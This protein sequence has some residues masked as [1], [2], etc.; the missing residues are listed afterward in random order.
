MAF[1]K[2]TRNRLANFVGKARDL[3]ADEF[4]QQFQSLYGISDNGKV[5][6]LDQLKHLDDVGQAA[7]AL[8]RERIDYFIKTHPEE[9]DGE[10]AAVT[11]LAREQAFT[12]LNRLAAI[13]MAEKRDL[14]V[15][16]VGKGYQSKGF[17][18]FEQV[19]GAGL[20]DTY[21]RYRRYIFCLFD[22]LAVDL[23]IL[24]DRRSPQG[25]LFPRET[26]LQ[27]L[28]TLLNAPDIEPLWGEDETIGWIYQYYNDPAERKKMRDESAAPR[29]SRELAVRNQ[30]FTPR[31]VVE[32][33]TDNT[34][35]RIWYEMTQ[36]GTSL[37]ESCRYLVRRPDEVFF[38]DKLSP[39]DARGERWLNGDDV[40]IQDAYDLASTVNAYNRYHPVELASEWYRKSIE[41]V[42]A[43]EVEKFKTQELLDLLFLVHRADHFCEGTLDACEK[44]IK[45]IIGELSKRKTKENID[46]LSQ[47]ELLRQP[48]YIPCREIKDPRKIGMLDP[49]CGSMHFGLY[50]FDLYEVIYE[51]AWDLNVKS[52]RHDYPDKNDFL[53]EV[54][55]LIIEHNIHGI[56]IDP[57]AVQIAGLSLWLRA[58]KSWQAQRIPAAQRPRITRSNIV[59][60]EPMPGSA[61]MLKEFTSSLHPPILGQLVEKVFDRMKLA[62]EA[63]S[64][65]KIEEE[66]AELI[67]EAKRLWSA[68]RKVEQTKFD[69]GQ[70]EEQKQGELPLDVSGIS[71]IQFWETAEE[72]IYKALKVYAEQV[73]SSTY[74]RRLFAE[75]AAQGFAFID[76]CR[77]KYDV[78][79]MNPPFGECSTVCID[80]IDKRLPFW[81][82]N[83]ASAFVLRAQSLSIAGGLNGVVSDKTV[84][85][86]SS[87]KEFRCKGLLD[88]FQ[89]SCF[90]DLGWEVLD[91]ANVEVIAFTLRHCTQLNLP[92]WFIDCRQE[93]DKS[94]LMRSAVLGNEDVYI[95]ESR[96]FLKLPNAAFA[97]DLPLKIMRVF[98]T[99]PT[100]RQGGARAL[101]GH[102]IKMDWYGRLAWEVEPSLIGLD[103]DWSRMYN[104]G[105]Y[106]TYYIPLIEI[107]RWNGNGI[108]LK[109]HKSTRWSNAAE[110][111]KPGIGYGKRGDVLD[112]HLLPDGFVFTVEGLAVMPPAI[113]NTW[114][115]LAILNSPTATKLIN[116][117]CGQHKH[118]GYIDL[119]PIPSSNYLNE[120]LCQDISLLA[121]RIWEKKRE[122]DRSNEI[123][124]LYCP[125]YLSSAIHNVISFITDLLENINREESEV[126]RLVAALY[127]VKEDDV[128]NVAPYTADLSDVEKDDE[129]EPPE[130]TENIFQPNLEELSK[131]N[132]SFLLGAI[133]GRWDIRFATG[134]RQPPELPD[135]FASLPVCP[136]G[137]LQNSEGLPAEPKDIPSNYPL[138]ISWKGILV[139]DENHPEDIVARV[140]EALEVIWK[141]RADAIEQEACE[142]LGVKN[143]RDYFRRPAGFFADHLKRY[144]KSRRQAPI[145][146]PLSTSSGSYT[147]WI[148][149]HR[150]NDQ[151]LHTTLADF[152][153]P[154][155]KAVRIEIN[156]LKESGKK[157]ARLE[158]LRD[159]EK[160][161]LDFHD[162]IERI[163]KLPWKPNL[164]DGVIITA[165]PLWK[166]FR[167]PKWQKDLKACWEKL[168]KGEYDWAHLAYS[169]W[170]KRVEEVCK[171][172]RSIAIAHN[173]EHLCEDQ[174]QK[175][176]GKKKKAAINKEIEL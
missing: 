120:Q 129:E 29:N 128:A 62:G 28:F 71:D 8:L 16:S 13:R 57:R 130:H 95:I 154:K 80:Y 106:S 143:L 5:T 90:A 113:Q 4:T 86:K 99:Q 109:N 51:E 22:E 70:V 171:K 121:Q 73:E 157:Q 159:L 104:G 75:D 162:E 68:P 142:L 50:A 92:G 168:E 49:A 18:V 96:A 39:A 55:R 46:G 2:T 54:P 137:M 172:D 149:Y 124:P 150:L 20:G 94:S 33:L 76:I 7:A 72:Q 31:Y 131:Q 125:I 84:V 102:A 77:E 85:I 25:L 36:G 35:G 81:C 93:T 89:P 105:S 32:F 53:I 38:D 152:V 144:S 141:E 6:P 24:F 78:V 98:N 59:C 83:L 140:R 56:D 110:Q 100:L 169:I 79:L 117:Y 173:L 127:N 148:Y 132:L 101:Q 123:S 176:K 88:S 126:N 112:A 58:Q 145:Y 17:K 27:E 66:I 103:R 122:L 37:K 170:P 167:L 133:W 12:V 65:L 44:E 23:G 21:H 45:S 82:G 9:R 135:A 14:I 156:S 114:Y 41:R 146:W 115:Y 153:D 111:Q 1:D 15:E 139:D 136:P 10:K 64:L 163:I 74:Q 175:T 60:A 42:T 34:L 158:E 43:G 40:E 107:V 52:L 118:A 134:E 30:F 155:I 48:V 19:A 91:N 119:L 161:L 166:L 108:F 69:L 11:R 26:A 174:S 138:R 160:E 63:G 47:E 61:E 87:Y 165:S 164:N 3:I 116:F 147:L 97:Y 67:S 151:T